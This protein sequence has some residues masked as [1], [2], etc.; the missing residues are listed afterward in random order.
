MIVTP[1]PDR[2]VRRAREIA[3]CF[4][5]QHNVKDNNNARLLL[6]L[7]GCYVH[8]VYYNIGKCGARV[9]LVMYN[10]V[11]VMY[12]IFLKLHVRWLPCTLF[13]ILIMSGRFRYNLFPVT[14]LFTR[15]DLHNGY[16]CVLCAPYTVII[17][18]TL[19]TTASYDRAAGGLTVGLANVVR[20]PTKNDIRLIKTN[21]QMRDYLTV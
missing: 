11:C 10:V 19:I 13:F 12:N 20:C 14:V 17:I 9:L 7:L 15:V 2:R 16:C 18:V 1:P 8:V 4:V 6:S 3:G 5:S 21:T